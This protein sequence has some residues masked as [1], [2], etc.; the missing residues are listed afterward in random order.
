MVSTSIRVVTASSWLLLAPVCT[1]ERWV[2]RG[3]VM[4][5]VS[6]LLLLHQRAYRCHRACAVVRQLVFETYGR[7]YEPSVGAYYYWN[8]KTG[9]TQWTKPLRYAMGSMDL[10]VT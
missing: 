6:W 2:C 8:A 10:P 7:T 4:T 3:C 9:A 5:G 1:C